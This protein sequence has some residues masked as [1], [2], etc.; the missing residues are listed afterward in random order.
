MTDAYSA[1]IPARDI[2]DDT[3]TTS[4]RLEQEA[5]A[6]LL[7]AENGTNS[8]RPLRD[9]V[10]E[11]ALVARDWGRDRALRLRGAVESEPVKATLYAL[12]LGVVIGLLIAR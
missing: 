11:D 1:P 10:R 2:E 6:I 12:G 8:P 5:D 3:D 7:D 9:A 4:A